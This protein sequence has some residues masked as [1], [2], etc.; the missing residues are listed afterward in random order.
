[1]F[2]CLFLR[3][4][5]II[6]IFVNGGIIVISSM[7]PYVVTSILT[8]IAQTVERDCADN[9]TQASAAVNIITQHLKKRNW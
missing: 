8:V 7:P 9:S 6:E 4:L 3:R 5:Q 2:A 1:M